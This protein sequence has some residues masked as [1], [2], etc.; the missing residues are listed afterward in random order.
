MKAYEI[1]LK[2]YSEASANLHVLNQDGLTPKSVR[3]FFIEA[4]KDCVRGNHA[5]KNCWQIITPILGNIEV[6]CNYGNEERLFSLIAFKSGL[7]VPPMNWISIKC[8][9]GGIVG[10]S[11][12]ENFDELDYLR[13]FD[14]YM[15]NFYKSALDGQ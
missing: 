3:Q 6:T 13:N 8:R 1:D 4:K 2:E 5:H 15:Q 10:V 14:I 7:V 9:K 11:A 12:T